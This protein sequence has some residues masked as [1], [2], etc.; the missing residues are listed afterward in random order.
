M[1]AFGAPAGAQVGVRNFP[2]DAL[3]ATMVVVQPPEIRMDGRTMR[4]S[5][6]ARIFGTTN[7]VVLSAS[8]VGQELTVNFVADGL[9]H[10]HQVWILTPAEAAEKRPR[11]GDQRNW[12][13]SADG[14]N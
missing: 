10:A 14:A 9:G 4:L 3:R 2:S 13:T 6:G 5:P 1:L 7:T 12:R 11:A 8:L